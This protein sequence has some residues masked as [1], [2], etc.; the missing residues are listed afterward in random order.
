MSYLVLA[1]K[2][3]PQTFE[4][5]T[6]QEHVTRTLTQ[7]IEQ[8]RVHHAF[9]FCGA[10]G[11][12]KTTAARVLARALNCDN[13]PTP[14]PCGECKPCIEIA[15]GTAVD[16]F[17]IDGASNRG[18]GEIRELREGIAY[19]PQ[20]DRYKLYIIDEVHMLTTEAFNALLKTLEEPP[21]HVKFI[22]ATTEPQKIPVTILC[23]RMR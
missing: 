14:T 10:R 12:G 2:W 18:I 8:D 23:Y 21:S 4:A 20:R 19:A 7:A 6:G 11:V 1:R 3:R 15:A 13:G 22:F 16:V 5:I 17:E 9:L